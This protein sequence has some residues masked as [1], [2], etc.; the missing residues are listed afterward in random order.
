MLSGRR[1]F[2]RDTAAETMTA[3]LKEEPPELAVARTEVPAGLDRIIRHCLE[4]NPGERFQ[5]AR[6][7]AFAL[8]ALSGSATST[9]HF[10]APPPARIR[11]SRLTLAVVGALVVAAA[12]GVVAGRA[13][14]PRSA[15]PMRFTTKTFD[16]QTIV[17]ARFMPD[18]ESLVF[19]S[20][21]TGNVV[22]LFEIR[23]GTVEARPFGPPR[24]HLLS[25]SSKG[26]LAVLTNAKYIAQRLF[27][28]TLARMSIEGSPRP[29]ME[30]VREAD[31]SPDGST[32]AIVHDM[33]SSDRVEYPIGKVLYETTGY[34]SDLRVSPDGNRVAFLDHQQRWDDRGWVK[35]VDTAAKV[36]T[37]AGEFWGAEG[38]AW[39]RDGAMLYFAA[40]NRSSA[41]ESRPGDVTYQVRSVRLDSAGTSSSALT[42]PGDF[43]IHDIA[44]D[45]RWLASREEIRL[46][47]GARLAGDTADRDLSWLNQNWAPRLSRDG[48]RLLFSDGTS[49]G[50]YG[51]VWRKTDDSPIVRLG[52]G[53]V[54]DWSPDEAWALA[55]TF[56]PAQLMLYPMGPGEPVRLKRGVI[57]EYQGALWFPDGKMLLIIGN[58]AR[59]PTRVYRQDIVGGEP[60]PWLQEGVIPAAISPDGQSILAINSD[61]KWGWYPASGGAARPAPGLTA[62]DAPASVIGW[63]A[64]GRAF[65][66][67]S[68]TEVPARIDRIDVATG[69]RTLLKQVGPTDLTGLATFDPLTVSRDGNQYAYRYR[70]V[71]STLFVVSR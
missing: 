52:D 54:L 19:S 66:V 67:H 35:I 15:A 47:V 31:W 61:R 46:G 45:G 57:A 33:G 55:Q 48:T 11:T 56:T 39:S 71:L 2:Q 49:G 53:N 6:D 51:V 13:M 16:P 5:S 24:T 32:L 34:V 26:E 60:M 44:A 65:F 22:Q 8:E 58:E 64:D 7:V 69:K 50:N 12:A 14:A 28:G 59:K 63:S 4:K 41:E 30:G 43:Y 29:W 38:L 40:N 37:L 3:I 20:A 25:V 18:G 27:Q 21:R 10:V 1:A 42:S 36:T 23:S 9:A 70:K 62:D 17:V 68:G